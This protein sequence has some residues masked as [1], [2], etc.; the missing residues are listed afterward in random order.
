MGGSQAFKAENLFAALL[1]SLSQHFQRRGPEGTA[2]NVTEV[3][4]EL[5][6]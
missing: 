3:M 2:P 4:V 5:T 1:H 6:R